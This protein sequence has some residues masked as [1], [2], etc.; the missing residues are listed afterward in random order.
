MAKVI[1]EN[2]N[3][4]KAIKQLRKKVAN[5]NI[6]KEYMDR[7][8]YKSKGELAREKKKAERRKQLKRMYLDRKY[9]KD[10]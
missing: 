6:L 8:Y 10:W 4:E 9:N 3:V 2:N 7:R 1:V 5:E